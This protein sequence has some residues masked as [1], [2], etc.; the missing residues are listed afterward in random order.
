MNN[1]LSDE[2]DR[3]GSRV[4]KTFDP[5][6]VRAL[7]RLFYL[8]ATTAHEATMQAASRGSVDEIAAT[9]AGMSAELLEYQTERED[10]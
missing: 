9:M 5:L 4:S 3:I 1:I 10:T 2:W 6:V 8:G 7:R